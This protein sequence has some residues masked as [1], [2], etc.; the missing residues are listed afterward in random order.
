M[1]AYKPKVGDRVVIGGAGEIVYI[2]KDGEYG[3]R[4]GD[5]DNGTTIFHKEDRLD[6]RKV[7][8]CGWCQQ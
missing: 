7:H 1:S 6:I 2:G 5:A 4:L 8:R 3:I